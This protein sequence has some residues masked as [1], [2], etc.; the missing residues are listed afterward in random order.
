MNS[1]EKNRSAFGEAL[2]K[3]FE[4]EGSTQTQLANATGVSPS[5]VNQT[6]S[7]K[8]YVSPEWADLV[9]DVLKM[10]N[11][12]RVRLHRAAARDAGFKLDLTK[13]KTAS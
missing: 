8:K 2:S 9:A 12:E 10:S 1:S 3:H 13:K 7:G 11:T 6:I 5:Y 4:R